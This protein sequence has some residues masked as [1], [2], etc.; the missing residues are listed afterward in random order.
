[1]ASSDAP[2]LD[3][4]HHVKL[5]VSDL[6]RSRAWYESR[7]G[8]QAGTEFVE[9]GT[10]MGVVM[11]H[12]NGGPPFGLPLFTENEVSYLSGRITLHPGDLLFIFTDGL[13]EAVDDAGGEY[14]EARLISCIE[15]DAA[16][17]ASE[18]LGRVMA[19][20][21]AFVGYAR[22]HDDITCFVLRVDV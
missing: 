17:T 2:E 9:N 8:Y 14:G 18:T 20:V 22:Q 21:N 19:D 1:M 12:P 3:G 6:D 16:K 11:M 5:P 15:N 10:M 4:V 7:L 13:I